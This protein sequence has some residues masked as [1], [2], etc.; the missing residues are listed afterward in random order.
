MKN[1]VFNSACLFILAIQVGCSRPTKGDVDIS[2]GSGKAV[3]AKGADSSQSSEDSTP[4]E[5]AAVNMARV[6][7][8]TLSKTP[9]SLG[10]QPPTDLGFI[11][12]DG[13]SL[14]NSYLLARFSMLGSRSLAFD[15]KS[16]PLWLKN[17]GFTESTL[18]ENVKYGVQGVVAVSDKINIVVFRGTH[19]IQGVMTD[20]AMGEPEVRGGAHKGFSEAYQSISKTFLKALEGEPIN[21][22]TYFV[23]HSLGGAIALLAALDVQRN[24]G[25][26]SG[27]L[28]LGQPRVGDGSFAAEAETILGDKLRRYVFNHDVIPHLPPSAGS[29]DELVK[30]FGTSLSSSINSDFGSFLGVPL[31]DITQIAWAGTAQSFARKNFTHVGVPLQLGN[32]TYVRT[33]FLD[34]DSWDQTFWKIN[35]DKFLTFLQKPEAIIGSDIILDHGV[36]RY[37]CAVLEQS[38][39]QDPVQ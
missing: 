23:G 29:S 30:A 28:T 17:A 2:D 18:L 9:I 12:E 13:L 33:S 32:S 16:L 6:P 1:T 15:A 20:V 7:V 3:R 38:Q 27:V 34:D 11:V 22:P 14:S 26:V 25:Q 10:C 39:N 8:F 21:R 4:P 37:L 5:K 19:S 35:R 24:K 36:E 31:G